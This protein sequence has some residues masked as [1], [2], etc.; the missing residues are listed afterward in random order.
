VLLSD[1]LAVG[2]GLTDQAAAIIKEVKRSHKEHMHVKGL[3]AE[4]VIEP[5]T[6]ADAKSNAVFVNGYRNH[7]PGL[8]MLSEQT[9]PERDVNVRSR[10]SSVPAKLLRDRDRVLDLDDVLVLVGPLDAT[11][12]FT[13]D[14]LQYVT[15]MVSSRFNFSITCV[16][17]T[18]TC[19]IVCAC[20]ASA[21]YSH[22]V[23]IN[24]SVVAHKQL[25]TLTCY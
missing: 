11:K 1:L 17:A 25:Y 20:C 6:D 14:L 8:P 15:T 5:V 9:E 4:G 19:H 22:V 3:T 24:L 7:F 21:M 13:E 2:L 16:L 12:E 18:S 10:A 23:I